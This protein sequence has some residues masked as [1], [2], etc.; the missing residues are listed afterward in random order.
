MSRPADEVFT[1][2]VAESYDDYYAS[3]HGALVDALEKAA[4]HALLAGV[5]RGRLLELGCGTGHW[6]AYLAA[7]G[8]DVVGMDLSEAMLDVAR[9]RHLGGVTLLRA[10]AER[11]P[12]AD[13]IV[14]AVAAV[15]VL[16]FV[17]DPT[18]V[19]C[20]IVRV[21]RPGGWFIGGFLNRES[22]LGL[23]TTAGA[24]VRHGRL[25]TP[26]EMASLLSPLGS[27][28]TRSCVRLTPDLE[29]LD[30]TPGS[31]TFP[32]AFVAIRAVAGGA[33]RP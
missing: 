15:A 24:I 2:E 25:L 32:P 7:Q 29:I 10:A 28:E 14:P 8:F 17:E 9:R 12:L 13:A 31:G 19:V 20:E 23:P 3:T 11:L 22:A 18:A 33:V 4:V 1:R 30:G 6:T 21:L 16:E 26:G 5:P 27:L